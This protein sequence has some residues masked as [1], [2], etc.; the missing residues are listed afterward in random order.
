MQITDEALEQLLVSAPLPSPQAHTAPA[1]CAGVV[2]PANYDPVCCCGKTFSN[3]CQVSACSTSGPVH[4]TTLKHAVLNSIF[5]P[6]QHANMFLH[7][8]CPPGPKSA[9]RPSAAA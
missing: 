9:C 7:S 3:S 4:G 2:C 8:A 6:M 1:G 5:A